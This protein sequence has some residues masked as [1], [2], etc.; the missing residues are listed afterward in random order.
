MTTSWSIKRLIKTLTVSG[1]LLGLVQSVVTSPVT[2]RLNIPEASF[3]VVGDPAPL[4][5]EFLNN[6]NQ[7]MAFMWEGCCRLNGRVMAK[8]NQLM[9]HSEISNEPSQITAHQFALAARMYPNKITK[10][11]TRISDWLII[12]KSGT[13]ELS[14]RYTGLLDTQ[15]PNVSPGWMLWKQTAK[16]DPINVTLL[17]PLDYVSKRTTL[18]QKSGLALNLAKTKDW[19]P[20]EGAKLQLTITNQSKKR[21]TL[22]WPT[23]IGLW[24]LNTDNR[25]VPLTPTQVKS[26]FEKIALQPNES[27]KKTVSISG[28]A[29]ESKSFGSY[30]IFLDYKNKNQRVPS[31]LIELNWK[32]NQN[33][34]TKL[35]HSASGGAKTGLRNKPLKILRM[36]IASIE[37]TLNQV[38]ME[39]INSNSKK[40]LKELQLAA[41]LKPL[42]PKPGLVKFKL[43]L[44]NDGSIRFMDQS[45]LQTFPKIVNSIDQI[46]NILN[47]RKHLG[48]AIALEIHTKTSQKNQYTAQTINHLKTLQ[49][50]LAKPLVIKIN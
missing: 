27:L 5:W 6:S 40:L 4:N 36:H 48:W 11:E 23:D 16:S 7:R 41:K 45:F 46:E 19:H 12:P 50:S 18:G 8:M 42:S 1:I 34:I 15:R 28:S 10:F 24:F 29:L 44:E 25:R 21:T 20:I 13:Y 37:Q 2:L 43:R 22:S 39:E 49:P 3:H 9:I 14:A 31:N 26:P 32:L 47:I 38:P 33:Q 30:R 17:T 35:I